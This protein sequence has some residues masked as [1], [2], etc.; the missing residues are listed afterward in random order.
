MSCDNVMQFISPQIVRCSS[1]MVVK[2]P[3]KAYSHDGRS[4]RLPSGSGALLK[5]RLELEFYG[6]SF[7]SCRWSN[8]P[9]GMVILHHHQVS[10]IFGHYFNS[11]N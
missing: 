10:A 7:K 9:S 2:N 5:V 3:Q 1:N 8:A 4:V 11:S 6:G